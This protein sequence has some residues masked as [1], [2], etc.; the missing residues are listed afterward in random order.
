MPSP[1]TWTS[2]ADRW[3]GPWVSEV[4][5]RTLRADALAGLVGALIVL[6]QGSA[7]AALAGLPPA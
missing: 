5:A 4:N 7:F 3:L 1:G 6:P 2:H